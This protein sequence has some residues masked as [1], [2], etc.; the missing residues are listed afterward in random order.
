MTLKQQIRRKIF[1]AILILLSLIGLSISTYYQYQ[2]EL[3]DIEKVKS[4]LTTVLNE[5][6]GQY[7]QLDLTSESS[8]RDFNQ[9]TVEA[10][11]SFYDEVIAEDSHELRRE[12]KYLSFECDS[13]TAQLN[14]GF[15]NA[16]TIDENYR[17][18]K[19]DMQ[20]V[21][22]VET[23]TVSIFFDNPSNL[24]VVMIATG[25]VLITIDIFRQRQKLKEHTLEENVKK[26][27]ENYNKSKK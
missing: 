21:I 25:L 19:T 8:I 2:G 3:D 15:I 18:L 26:E 5:Y 16:E 1:G 13:L 7:Q 11:L 27:I 6:D 9:Q 17:E 23:N 22:D 10:C 14:G 4:E 20:A 12:T 24:A